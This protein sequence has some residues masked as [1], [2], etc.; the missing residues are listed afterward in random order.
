M[1]CKAQIIMKNSILD[2]IDEE[3]FQ[4]NIDTEI[5]ND[6]LYW[7][8]NFGAENKIINT[9]IA[10]NGDLIA[11][12]QMNASGKDLV[13]IKI[14]NDLIINWRPKLNTAG[15]H[16]TGCNFI[17]FFEHFLIVNYQDKH[18]E[19]TFV[20]DSKKLVDKEIRSNGYRKKLKL[21]EN[22][23]FIKNDSTTEILKLKIGTDHTIS[24]L[25]T[26]DFLKSK[27]ITF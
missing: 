4:D 8:D 9:M 23:L 1:Y 19:R 6:S 15:T 5:R 7:I 24:E 3:L 12:W 25:V 26:E 13:R 11:W 21:V 20:F 18:R 17:E 10:N 14:S 2:L 27:Q 22:N 16:S